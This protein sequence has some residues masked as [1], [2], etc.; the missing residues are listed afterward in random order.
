MRLK[1]LAHYDS[2]TLLGGTFIPRRTRFCGLEGDCLTLA[3]PHSHIC[4]C[5]GTN[6]IRGWNYDKKHEEVEETRQDAEF[7]AVMGNSAVCGRVDMVRDGDSFCGG[8]SIVG[9]RCNK[10]PREEEVKTAIR[11]AGTHLV[12]CSRQQQQSTVVKVIFL[13][14]GHLR[15]NKRTPAIRDLLDRQIHYKG[16]PPCLEANGNKNN[17]VRLL[18]SG[19]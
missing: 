9:C 19:R 13:R 11:V 14:V 18:P 4:M 1:I 16:A 12:V 3:K 7:V 6:T 2:P 15:G 5:G 10:P 8:G 17:I